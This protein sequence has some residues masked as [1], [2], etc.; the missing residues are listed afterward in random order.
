MSL[1]SAPDVPLLINSPNSQSERRINPSW[2]IA[3]FKTRL[4]PITGIPTGCQQLSL[5]VG[6]QDAVAITAADEEQT[7]LGAFALQPYAE[8]TVVDTRPPAARTDFSDLSAV[9][10]YEMPA[11]EYE[12]RSDSV[13]AWKKA[14][15][16]GRFDPNAPSVEEQ[17]IQALER[18]IEERGLIVNGRVRLLPD[19][20]AR[21][22][23][24]SYIGNIPEIPGLG[25]WIGVTLDEPTGKNDGSVKG[26]KY[27]E[28][29][30]NCGV[31]VRPERCEAGDFPALDLGDEDLEEL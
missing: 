3:A 19:S 30:K 26:K 20:D 14:Q 21:R 25:A 15:K 22:G 8:I 7:Q 9:A 18:E 13:L 4:E 12:T 29:G 27:F 23:T 16:L 28:C 10:K 5:R 31:F 1:H 6:S 2:T 17:K 11:T 24:I